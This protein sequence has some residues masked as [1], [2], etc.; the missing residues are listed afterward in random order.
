M[1][2]NLRT[3]VDE[4]KFESSIRMNPAEEAPAPGLLLQER[5]FESGQSF[6]EDDLFDACEELG[7]DGDGAVEFVEEL[8]S[9]Y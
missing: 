5:I 2:T 7:M 6:T 3:M 8:A 9:W 4:V 1:N